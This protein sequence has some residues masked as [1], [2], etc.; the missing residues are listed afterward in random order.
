M[1]N[2]SW[3]D[4]AVEKSGVKVPEWELEPMGAEQKENV[5]VSVEAEPS[6]ADK[7]L[8]E[9]RDAQAR[10][11]VS[12]DE[13]VGAKNFVVIDY[14]ASQGGKALPNA[15]GTSD[16]PHAARCANVSASS[17]AGGSGMNS[18]LPAVAGSASGTGTGPSRDSADSGKGRNP[19]KTA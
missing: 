4:E 6:V 1:E 16:R 7:R 2:K 13:T 5:E 10:L 19:S 3:Q 15:K 8:E 18:G 17:P 11:D 14:S 12:K 9:L